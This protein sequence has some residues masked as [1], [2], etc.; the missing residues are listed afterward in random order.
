LTVSPAKKS[1]KFDSNLTQYKISDGDDDDELFAM[2]ESMDQENGEEV[3]PAVTCSKSSVT[4]VILEN[5]SFDSG[6]LFSANDSLFDVS[7]TESCTIQTI[8]PGLSNINNDQ[9]IDFAENDGENDL[10]LSLSSVFTA[11]NSVDSESKYV[12]RLITAESFSLD[13]LAYNITN[14]NPTLT[15]DALSVLF[16]VESPR[17]LTGPLALM[18]QKFRKIGPT[19]QMTFIDGIGTEVVGT[20]GNNSLPECKL[21]YGMIFIL[22]DVRILVQFLLTSTYMCR[23]LSLV[24]YQP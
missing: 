7:F 12:P 13:Q 3:I 14:I 24:P 4:Q 15:L 1:V 19:F 2:L 5:E 20:I 18:V 17:R 6:I 21:H 22:Q 11:V 23:F 9:P 16:S 8:N 10:I